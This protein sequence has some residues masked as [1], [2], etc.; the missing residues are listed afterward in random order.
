[1][2]MYTFDHRTHANLE[3]E[4]DSSLDTTIKPKQRGLD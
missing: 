4:G 1:M 2:T 3:R